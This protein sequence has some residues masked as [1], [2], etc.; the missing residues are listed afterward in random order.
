MKRYKNIYGAKPLAINEKHWFQILQKMLEIGPD[1]K[2]GFG[3]LNALRA[4]KVL[5]IKCFIQLLLLTEPRL[6][7]NRCS[8][9][10]GII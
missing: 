9:W 1:Y 2:Y 6:K 7:E 4:V 3:N 10:F 5:T 8:S